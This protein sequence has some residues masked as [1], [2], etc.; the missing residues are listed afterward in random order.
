M[1]RK[2]AL[3]MLFM[4]TLTSV[5][6]SGG[7]GG[8]ILIDSTHGQTYY[9]FQTLQQYLEHYYGLTVQILEEPISE[10]TLAGASVLF[11]PCP[12]QNTSFTPEEL[13]AIVNFV[14][15]GG[16]LLLGCDSQYTYGG[17]NYTYGQPSTLNTVLEALGIADK[18][19]YTGTNTLGDQLLDEYENTGREFEPVISEFPEH[20][21]TAFMSG[22]K[23]IYYGC[24]L[25]VEDESIIVLR[26]GPNAYSVDIAGRK[27][28]EEG[29]RPPVA[30]ALEVGKGKVL[31]SGST[32]LFSDKKTYGAATSIYIL[33]EQTYQFACNVF[34]WLSG[35]ESIEVE[36][37]APKKPVKKPTENII[38]TAAAPETEI[39]AKILVDA[40]HGEYFKPLPSP[41]LPQTPLSRWAQIM[42]ENGFQVDQLTDGYIT[43]DL[44]QNYDVLV[45]GEPQDIMFSDEEIQAIHK[46]VEN[47]GGL[48][49]GTSW[50]RYNQPD[51][52]N[53]ISEVFG[54]KFR[55]DEIMDDTNNNGRAYYPIISDFA[56][57]P[58]CQGVSAIVYNGGSL[59]VYGE[60][61]PVA[62][63]DDDS[64]ALDASGIFTV[65][66]GEK[67]VAIAV[68]T[69]GS[70]R[71][72]LTGGLSPYTDNSIDFEDNARMSVNMIVWLAT[73]EA[74]G[75]V[76]VPITIP[77]ELMIGIPML[78]IG[79][80]LLYI[81]KRR[82]KTS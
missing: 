20:P 27:T 6:S 74:P 71:V 46:F 1:S 5:L 39:K 18:V 48:L 58:V 82:Q 69:Y 66:I 22:K 19:R 51:I 31:V 15:G 30:A 3:V 47:G 75:Q 14:N 23:M 11:I 24:T 80:L 41:Q 49:L 63:G 70:G 21:V 60:A 52:L 16:G 37:L 13:D 57:H 62:W 8:L 17:R 2:I 79:F 26:G 7:Q 44:L 28:Y 56:D 9:T 73:G 40:A 54:V 32:R 59:E 43:L 10:A 72:V 36:F 4:L 35:I 50:Y 64:Y 55:L 53:P 61:K 38:E 77:K 12:A 33:Y 29:S 45:I 78:V 34:A 42:A 81:V 68:A 76:E 25:Q 65:R 67:P